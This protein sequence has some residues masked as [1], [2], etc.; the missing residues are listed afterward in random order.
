MAAADPYIADLVRKA[1]EDRYLSTLYAPAEKRPALLALYAFDA[2]IARVRDLVSEPMPGEIRLQWW[3]DVIEAG[4]EDAGGHPVAD[5]LLAAIRECR[6]PAKTFL[7]YLEARTFDLYDDPMPNRTALEGY[8]GET[9]SAI[10]QLAGLILDPAGA[11]AHASSAGHAGCAAGILR[12]LYML[13][14]HRARG[15]CY[16]PAEMLAAA[17]LD[18]EAYLAGEPAEAMNAMVEVTKALAGEHLR[19]FESGAQALPETLLPAFL[20]LATLSSRLG[21]I[22]PAIAWRAAAADISFL[23]RHWL[24]FRRATRGWRNL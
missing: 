5:A 9:W 4:G 21:R 12:L 8:C 1:D 19:A 20:P 16:V 6:L 13:P 22:D 15:Q 18:R 3:R 14:V 7:D 17:G 11:A 24:L 10:I 23:R 2:E